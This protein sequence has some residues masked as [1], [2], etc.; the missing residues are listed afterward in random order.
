MP[1]SLT[2]SEVE[3]IE[4]VETVWNYARTLGDG[5]IEGYH[6]S[7]L[8]K[9]IKV[10]ARRGY[11]QPYDDQERLRRWLRRQ[12]G[13]THEWVELLNRIFEAKGGEIRVN[14][15]DDCGAPFFSEHGNWVNDGDMVCARCFEANYRQCSACEKYKSHDEMTSIREYGMACQSCISDGKVEIGICARCEETFLSEALYFNEATDMSYCQAHM[16]M[17]QCE[18]SHPTFEF[19]ALCIPQKSIQQDEIVTITV[20]HG[21]VTRVG[22]NEIRLYIARLTAPKS[23]RGGYGLDVVEIDDPDRFD[24]AWQT[25]E[26]NFPKRLAKHLLVERSLKLSESVMAEVGNLA[27]A[28]ANMGPTTHCL[29]ITRDI[30]RESEFYANDGSCWWGSESHSRCEL[31]AHHGFAVRTWES[32]TPTR[33]D[34]PTSRAWMIPLKTEAG[35]DRFAFEST[36]VLPADAYVLFNAYNI[37][38]L[39]YARM[40]A[41]MVGKSYRRIG[42]DAPMYLNSGGVLIAEQSVCDATTSVSIYSR[43]RCHGSRCY[44]EN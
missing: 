44:R 17:S 4:K 38:Q 21:D 13:D 9:W 7:Q 19:P 3:T 24:P 37:E 16:P 12:T 43:R 28:H 31:K 2:A 32:L 26:G 11:T 23:S 41:G 8:I 6:A 39:P 14:L 5:L 29:S 10:T 40:I 35:G 20:P 22:L 34:T 27:K 15:C 25:R 33:Y 18:P 36:P 42:F 1:E 30:N